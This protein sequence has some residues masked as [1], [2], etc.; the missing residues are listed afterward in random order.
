MISARDVAC[1]AVGVLTGKQLGGA[2][3]LSSRELLAE[4][5]QTFIE[6]VGQAA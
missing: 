3:P 4:H 2:P 5:R 6:L 1:V